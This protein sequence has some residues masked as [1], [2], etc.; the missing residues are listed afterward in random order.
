MRETHHHGSGSISFL[1]VDHAY[2]MRLSFMTATGRSGH[3][4]EPGG[5]RLIWG[6]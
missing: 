1:S 5:E 3:S 6:G 2:I 4:D